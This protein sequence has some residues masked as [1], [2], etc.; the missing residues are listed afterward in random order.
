MPLI[1]YLLIGLNVLVYLAVTLPTSAVVPD[2][3]DPAVQEY[4]RFLSEHVGRNLHPAE[5]LAGVS[6]Y[7][8]LIYE[9]GYR[10]AHGSI[11]T[12]FTSLFLHG[13]LM[14]LAGNM[15]F[16]WIYGDNVEHRLG[17]VRYLIA[18]LL[19]GVAATLFYSAFEMDSN[20]PLVGASGAISG[21][22][23]FYFLFFP[24]NTVRVFLV[25]F[26][27]F[28]DV[29]TIPARIVLGVY[30]VVDNLFPA[31]F[32]SGGGVAHGAHIGGFIAGL[33]A[34]WLID[35]R[36]LTSTP[37]E[38]R[39]T[40]VH[41]GPGF[42][43]RPRSA[44]RPTENASVAISQLIRQGQ[45]AD[46]AKVYFTSTEG[47]GPEPV[48][49][50]ALVLG[51]WLAENGHPTAALT[52]FRRVLKL[53]PKGPQAAWAHIGAGLVQLE[54]LDRPTAAYQHFLDAIDLEPS[55]EPA[56]IARAGIAQIDAQGSA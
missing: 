49:A 8:I 29:V 6:A 33:G 48:P 52:V 15:L 56:R 16:L 37:R 20:V 39:E 2:V 40:P 46:A 5:A 32:A 26:P 18:Y 43:G 4:V 41:P 10:P 12:M 51:R 47:A 25:L 44:A 3:L 17:K 7:D 38:Y 13:G 21:V 31:L 22:L 30:L 1:N 14:H 9:W 50:D 53:V 28:V 45:M 27:F 35:R 24:R 19:T 36:E 54:D 42:P 55:G 23:G 34:A 11:Q